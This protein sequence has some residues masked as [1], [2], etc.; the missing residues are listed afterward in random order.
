MRSATEHSGSATSTP[1]CRC[2]LAEVVGRDVRGHPHRD[3]RGAVHQQVGEA[4]R[5]DRG[6]LEP[7]VEVGR[8][9]HRLLLEIGEEVTGDRGQPGLGVPVGR[10]GVP[11][12]GAE[13][14][15]PVHEGVA[16][17]EVLDHPHHRVVDRAVP[18][19]VVLPQHLSHDRGALL[20]RSI[21]EQP[22]PLIAK[23]I[24]RWTGL[25]PSRTSGRARCTITL[26]E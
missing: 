16:Q 18:V 13:V 8:P 10:S 21:G 24:R 2:D 26:M 11:V 6:F 3:P 7:I 9:V 19:R 17:R 20:V 5:Q 14:P 12:D 1:E 15:L 23:R 4:R 22:E 25:R